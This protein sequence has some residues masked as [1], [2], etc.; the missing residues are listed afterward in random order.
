VQV[1]NNVNIWLHRSDCDNFP[2]R[3]S[4]GWQDEE[5][6]CKLNRLVNLLGKDESD[7]LD[8]LVK[9]FHH[10]RAES[11]ET[12]LFSLNSWLSTLQENLKGDNWEMIIMEEVL[13]D[14]HRQVSSLASSFS[15]VSSPSE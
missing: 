9:D 10:S 3:I 11:A 4:G 5:A 14:L 8:Y 7:W 1:A 13:Q 6:T 2:F 15:Q 12:Y